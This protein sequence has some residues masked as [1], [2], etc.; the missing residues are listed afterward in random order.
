MCAICILICIKINTMCHKIFKG[1][2][3]FKKFRKMEIK[4]LGEAN[5]HHT[6]KRSFFSRTKE[7]SNK[8]W[9]HTCKTL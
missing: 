9:Q 3:E 6:L 8:I 4:V 5:L 2:L 7:C 1:K